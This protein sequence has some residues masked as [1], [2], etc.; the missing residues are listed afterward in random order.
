MDALT[1][2]LTDLGLENIALFSV[3]LSVALVFFGLAKSRRRRTTKLNGPPS[4]SYMFG[5][6]GE[7]FSAPEV[8]VIY[9]NWAKQY[10]PVFSI[11]LIMGSKVVILCDPKAIAHHYSKDTFTYHQ[12]PSLKIVNAMHFGHNL[13]TVEGETHKRQRRALSSAFSVAAIR[14]L[15]P[16]FYDS[17]YMVK[18]A[19]DSLFQ[20]SS[21]DTVIIEVQQWMDRV[22]LDSIG[23]G[24]F[25]HDFGSLKGEISPIAEAFESFGAVKPSVPIMLAFLLSSVFPVLAKIPNKRHEALRKVSTSVASIADD[26]LESAR[27]ESATDKSI[28]GALIRSENASSRIRIWY[29]ASKTPQTTLTSLPAQNL[30][31]GA[32]Y[33]TTAISLT[34]AL[35]ELSRKPEIQAKLRDELAASSR[36]DPSYEQLTNGLPYLDAV[37]C[38]TLR[39]HPALPETTRVAEEDDVIPLT[40]PIYNADGELV[41]SIFI[42]KGTKVRVPIQCLNTAEISWGDNSKDFSPERWLEQGASKQRAAEIQ[43]YRHLLSF[44]D[45]PRTCLGRQFALTEFKA[46]LSVLIR[47]F[48]FEFPDGPTTKIESHR[49]VLVRPKVAGQEGPKVP[50][51]VRRVE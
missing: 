46:V 5:V 11:P 33:E 18:A 44:A 4:K 31:I 39:L 16:V 40:S 42:A 9:K 36:E 29:G 32:G 24:G 25:S 27:L 17:A 23:T 14:N 19:W 45:G 1:K 47:N 38:E 30:L 50:L 20:N 41:D 12:L 22:S 35:I 37:A 6:G 34:W 43:G 49:S 2:R 15:T 13:L 7:L 3:P 8:G 48:S 21:D 28:I 51:I 10:G 26:L